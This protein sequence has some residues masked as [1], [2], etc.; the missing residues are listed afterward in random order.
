MRKDFACWRSDTISSTLV[1]RRGSDSSERVA[2][3]GAR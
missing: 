1:I 3:T 2:S